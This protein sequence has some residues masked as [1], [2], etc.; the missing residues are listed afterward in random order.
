VSSLY[1]CRARVGYKPFRSG[2]LVIFDE[3]QVQDISVKLRWVPNLGTYSAESVTPAAGVSALSQSKCSVTISDP[4]L[5]GVAWPALYDAASL[6]TAAS[7]SAANGI[8]LPPCEEG[9]D[10][11][12]DKCTK[13]VDIGGDTTAITPGDDFAMLY[14]SLWYDVAGT[15]FG[16]DFYFR[17]D[18][19]SISH[20]TKY[21][22]V[23]IKGVDAR[24][25]VFN[26]SLVNM[27]FEEGMEIE[28]ALK[29]IAETVGFEPQ[30]CANTNE[31]PE[32][33]RVIPRTM[34]LKGVTPDEAIS[35]I[36]N[37][38]NGNTL[39]LPTQQWAN[40]ISM[41]A[42]GE[43]QQ[44]CQVFYLGRGLYEGYEIN[45]TPELSL[46]QSNMELGLGLNN[47]DP[48]TSEMFESQLY[49]LYD[50]VPNLRKE[51]TKN[52]KKAAFP[53]QFEPVS[54]HLQSAPRL[55]GFAW[56]NPTPA[57]G[58]NRKGVVVIH[59]RLKDISLFGIAPNGTTAISFL[60]GK[61]TEADSAQGRVRIDTNFGLLICKPEDDKKC[62]ARKIRQETSGL[63]GGVRVRAGQDVQ[64]SEEIGSS[65]AERPEFTRF[66]IEG[67]KGED[68]TLSPQIVWDYAI[69]QG[70]IQEVLNS[71]SGEAAPVSTK[72]GESAS[73]PSSSAP[74]ARTLEVGRIG[75]TGSSS[76]PHLHVET[77]PRG[78]GI[79]EG[80]LDALVNKYISFPTKERGRGYQGHGY[81]G[82]DYPAAPGSPITLLNGASVAEVVETKCTIQNV[83]ENRCGGGFG[84][85]L[86]INTPDGI[87]ILLAHLFPESIP[88]NIVGFT[89]ASGGGKTGSSLQSAPAAEGL[90]METTFKGVPRSLRIVPG[91]TILSFI[92]DYDAWVENGGPR[93]NDNQTDPGVWIPRRF[94][95]WFVKTCDYKW[96]GGD[97]RVSIEGVSQWGTGRISVPTFTN[98]LSQ[99]RES[100]DLKNTSDYYGY[101]RS[102]GDLHWKEEGG[103]DSTEVFCP[104]AQ[105]WAPASSSGADSTQPGDVQSSYPTAQCQYVGS[106]YNA[107]IVQGIID[108]SQAGGIKTKEGYAAAVGNAIHESR[109]DPRARGDRG[110]G[111]PE[112]A[113]AWGIF[114]W[115]S[116]RQ[117]LIDF[118]RARGKSPNDFGL[119]MQFYVYEL[120][121]KERATVPA[122]NAA[123]GVEA[124]TITFEDKY[125]RAGTKAYPSRI[126]AAQEIFNDLKCP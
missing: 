94:S 108:A 126:S 120:Q 3:R 87:K 74:Q 103:K 9:Q 68:V 30:F 29:K 71:V 111:C 28:E 25:I 54:P 40:K 118:A 115:N 117:E 18:G 63:S 6:Y 10:P 46:L 96:R 34:R 13:Y 82:I 12:V 113:C 66:F 42:R 24:S 57:Q 73:P 91:R 101:I 61:V 90:S 55:N 112:G 109:L 123:R 56:K 48:Y 100:G 44:G 65:T 76:G 45:G 35:K 81:P 93:G 77:V 88:A 78:S 21:P 95:N 89:A 99:M 37:S 31:F 23:T 119:Q 58:T 19:F 67:H 33:R 49:S 38:V 1:R 75:S 70:S 59:E 5:T 15:S 80:Q 26:Q 14:V 50:P 43:I 125:E 84:N 72:A 114:Q 52:V 110:S 7:V 27:S 36:I 41:C 64:I 51:A 92:T 124:A 79:S 105:A 11:L 107:S 32:K 4:Y 122:V 62:F 53:G 106:K 97:L 22:S 121:N 116:R 8:I 86:I 98:Y 17:V 16:T 47:G 85:H 69:P 83:R 39:H 20:G 2:K 104:E 102:I 60:S